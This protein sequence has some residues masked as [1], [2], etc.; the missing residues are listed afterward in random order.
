MTLPN[1]PSRFLAAIL[2]AGF[3]IFAAH[4]HSCVPQREATH[5]G[6]ITVTPESS[7]PALEDFSWLAGR[8]EGRLG[9]VTAE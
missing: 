7:K 5:A 9:P 8:W 2:F 4:A 6:I 1:R 3:S